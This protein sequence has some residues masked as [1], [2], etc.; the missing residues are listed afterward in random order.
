[1]LGLATGRFEPEPSDAC[2]IA[3]LEQIGGAP[4]VDTVRAAHNYLGT[5]DPALIERLILAN[6]GMQVVNYE[7]FEP[8]FI[9]E[10][11]PD[12]RQFEW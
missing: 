8:A 2:Q 10:A 12:W 5:A 6:Q 9:A 11:L 3:F 4:L 7:P 1:M